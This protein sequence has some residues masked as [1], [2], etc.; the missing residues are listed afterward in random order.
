LANADPRNAYI[1]CL[2]SLARAIHVL[3]KSDAGIGTM[4]ATAE[5]I[6]VA[7]TP[8]GGELVSDEQLFE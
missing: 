6:A 2:D 3:T 7:G 1:V 8:G 5:R 4:L